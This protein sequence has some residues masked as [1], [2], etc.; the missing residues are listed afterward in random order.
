MK[1]D[2]STLIG[3]V[4]VIVAGVVTYLKKQGIF[5]NKHNMESQLD[6]V[7]KNIAINSLITDL[8]F[9]F[10]CSNVLLVQFHNGTNFFSGHGIIKMVAS[11]ERVGLEGSTLS[12]YA[13]GILCSP[14]GEMLKS[15]LA[16]G[17]CEQ[18]SKEE[19]WSNLMPSK[20]DYSVNVACF[21]KNKM[22]GYIKLCWHVKPVAIDVKRIVLTV[23]NKGVV[24][25]LK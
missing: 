13:Q 17:Y 9:H 2:I 25:F 21:H 4:I 1:Y 6:L 15:L 20:I 3:S 12:H 19:K 24:E 16:T 23:N 22:L 11:H 8:C 7:E 18:E 14:Y 5:F 10:K